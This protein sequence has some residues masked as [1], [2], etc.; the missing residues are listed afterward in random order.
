[1]PSAARNAPNGVIEG[2]REPR[3]PGETPVAT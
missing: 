3:G 2:W 1:M